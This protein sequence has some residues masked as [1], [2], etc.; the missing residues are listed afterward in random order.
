MRVKWHGN[1]SKVIKNIMDNTPTPLKVV[2]GND[3]ITYIVNDDNKLNDPVAALAQAQN[4]LTDAQASV[5][6]DQQGITKLQDTLTKDQ[7]IL[8]V[9]KEDVST[10]T[11]IVNPQS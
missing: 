3:G 10:L 8:A 1:L 5:D 2:T 9:R 11:A 4:D 6:M 7:A